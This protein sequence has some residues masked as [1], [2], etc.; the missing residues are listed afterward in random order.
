MVA[1]LASGLVF[2]AALARFYFRQRCVVNEVVVIIMAIIIT[3]I[4]IITTTTIMIIIII[5]M[6]TPIR[7]MLIHSWFFLIH[8]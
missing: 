7:I 5:I 3:P 2:V 8:M 1:F 6:I 4:I